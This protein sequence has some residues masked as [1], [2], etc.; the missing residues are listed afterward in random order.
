MKIEE[1]KEKAEGSKKVP[2]CTRDNVFAYGASH[3]IGKG[4]EC[5]ENDR[6]EDTQDPAKKKNGNFCDLLAGTPPSVP[7][8]YA[9]PSFYCIAC[10]FSHPCPV[11]TQDVTVPACLDL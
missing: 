6:R 7:C 10:L 5:K 1:K 11:P 4:K 9:D 2:C 8:P 3:D